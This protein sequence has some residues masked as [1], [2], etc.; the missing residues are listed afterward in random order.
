MSEPAAGAPRKRRPYAARMPADQ[1]REQVLDVALHIAASRGL[2]DVTME[3]I[4]R[5]S[6]VTKPVV[7]AMFANAESVLAALVEREQARAWQQLQASVPPDLDLSDPLAAFNVGVS[8]F[9]GAIRANRETWTLLLAADQLPDAA[10]AQHDEVRRVLVRQIAEFAAVGLRDRP[11]GP[12]D[13]ELLAN[14]IVAGVEGS[15]RLVL[16]QP[17]DFS[18]ERLAAFAAELA[19]AVLQS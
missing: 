18:E 1:R 10:R 16:K 19:R 12:L 11:S 9:L 17:D 7:Y 4:A 6:G 3:A 5:E 13:P 8:R 14:L 2:R 15:A